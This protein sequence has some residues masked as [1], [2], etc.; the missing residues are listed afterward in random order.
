[1]AARAPGGRGP[2]SREDSTASQAAPP[3]PTE[4]L[5]NTQSTSDALAAG[6]PSAAGKRRRNHRGGKKKKGRRQSFLPTT[7]EGESSQAPNEAQT[8]GSARPPFYRLGQSGGRNL[9]ETSLD[10]NALLDHR[11]VHMITC[12][13]IESFM[14]TPNIEIISP[15]VKEETAGSPQAV[16]QELGNRLTT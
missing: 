3:R 4:G 11:Q 8:P 7:G 14:L 13:S 9:S 12:L 1:M 5:M 16:F 10:S 2:S 6:D 15:C